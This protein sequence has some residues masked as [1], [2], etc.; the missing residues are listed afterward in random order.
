MIS[1]TYHNIFSLDIILQKL[2]FKILNIITWKKT[3]S[4]PNFSSPYLAHSTKQ[5]IWAKKSYKHKHIFNYK[6]LKKL[7][8]DKQMKDFWSFSAISS[9]EGNR[10]KHPTQKQFFLLI[11][12]ILEDSIIRDPFSGSST[13]RIATNLLS[14]KFVG[15]E[16]EKN[17]IDI[18]TARKNELDNNFYL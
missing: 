12:L 17:F 15:F 9:W 14:R 10:K 5:T 4:S 1:G 8:D 13:T 7:N 3:N 16:K 6:L 11:R 18:S 2:D